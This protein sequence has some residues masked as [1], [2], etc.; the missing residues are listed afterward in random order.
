MGK[1]SDDDI[2]MLTSLFEG[3]SVAVVKNALVAANGDLDRAALILAERAA[4]AEEAAAAPAAPTSSSSSSSHSSATSSTPAMP[5]TSAA[6]LDAE[7]ASLVSQLRGMLGE[8]VEHLAAFAV[9]QCRRGTG[10]AG[11]AMAAAGGSLLDAA[12]LYIL[13]GA[14]QADYEFVAQVATSAATKGGAGEAEETE[15]ERAR[16]KKALLAKF[17]ETPD[18]SGV[19][20]KP[21]L[22]AQPVTVRAA[23]ARNFASQLEGGKGAKEVRYLEGQVVHVRKG[24]KYITETV[25]APEDPGTFVALKVKR[26]RA[27]GPSP[28]W[29]K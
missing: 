10:G 6:P 15:A 3:L 17:D 20:Y 2:E 28:G 5:I 19:K 23:Q 9:S 1:F 27:A 12:A 22:A 7:T 8:E 26:K 14:A 13:E 25:G 16:R 4:S 11:A 21:S 29:G 18:D 24:E